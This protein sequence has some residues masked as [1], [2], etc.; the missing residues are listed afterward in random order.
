MAEATRHGSPYSY[1]SKESRGSN[2]RRRPSRY[3]YDVP[4]RAAEADDVGDAEESPIV[5]AEPKA[6]DAPG[7]SAGG[8][9][10]S[11]GDR[12]GIVYALASCACS[13]ACW[14]P[15]RLGYD[16]TP[17]FLLMLLACAFSVR[18][19]RTIPGRL[20]VG[21]GLVASTLAM[22]YTFIWASY[23]L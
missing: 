17:M 3:V 21:A 8:R 7:P 22:L 23:T 18:G 20:I 2:A 11:G 14:V 12:A 5:G 4:E 13:C 19:V 15:A 9:E 1:R 6:Y 16:L 10:K